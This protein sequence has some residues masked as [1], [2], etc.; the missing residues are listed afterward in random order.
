MVGLG[1]PGRTY[2]QTRHNIGFQVID[3]LSQKYHISFK[4]KSRFAHLLFGRGEVSGA[5]VIFAKPQAYMNRSGGPVCQ[6]ANYYRILSSHTIVVHD[7]IDLAFGRIK[8]KAKGG[9]AGH[10]GVKS[11]I[12]ILGKDDFVRVRIGIGR[13][14]EKETVDH[15]LGSFDP[16]E[17]RILGQIISCACDAVDTL[18]CHGTVEGMNRY[19]NPKYAIEF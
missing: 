16:A 1:N 17:T 2:A 9:P 11:L 10:K 18:L 13:S 14:Q 7:D 4:T 19:N 15:V 5:P 12:D 6:I 3:H 8:I